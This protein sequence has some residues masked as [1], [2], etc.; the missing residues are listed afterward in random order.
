MEDIKKYNVRDSVF[1][2]LFEKSFRE[3]TIE[4]LYSIVKEENIQEIT[5]TNK[6]QQVVN[7]IVEHQAEIDSIISKYS[8]TRSIERIATANLIILRLAIYEILFDDKVPTNTAV[9]EAVK[10]AETYSAPK[11]VRFINGLLGAFTRNVEDK[12]S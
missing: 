9:Y 4:E 11:D 8:T 5:I 10:L 3:D 1:K 12:Q 6:V 2:I 7:G